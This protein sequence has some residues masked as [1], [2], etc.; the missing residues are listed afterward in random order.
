M[1]SL[2]ECGLSMTRSTAGAPGGVATYAGRQ[3]QR[4]SVELTYDDGELEIVDANRVRTMLAPRNPRIKR[5]V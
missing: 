4:H 2:V 1:H 5:G 3:G